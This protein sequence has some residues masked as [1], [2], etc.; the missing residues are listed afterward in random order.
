MIEDNIQAVADGFIEEYLSRDL[1]Y[2]DVAEFV[3][4]WN[5]E[6]T[7]EGQDHVYRLVYRRA[8]ER[9]NQIA[10]SFR[11]DKDNWD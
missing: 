1:E 9:L 4:E 5:E 2:L 3:D 6:D 10:E 8:T 7:D 11:S